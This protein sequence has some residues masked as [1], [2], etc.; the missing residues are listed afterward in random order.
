MLRNN[1]KTTMG[2]DLSFGSRS[3]HITEPNNASNAIAAE[4]ESK[5]M[6]MVRKC[7]MGPAELWALSLWDRFYRRLRGRFG[8]NAG[9]VVGIY[10]FPARHHRKHHR[11]RGT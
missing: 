11:D 9:G 5:R 7:G 4:L 2:R 10:H 8:Q 1:P 6:A 3:I